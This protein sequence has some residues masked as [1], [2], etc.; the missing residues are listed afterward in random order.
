MESGSIIRAHAKGARHWD[1]K[2]P[3]FPEEQ[4]KLNVQRNRLYI[5]GGHLIDA[6]ISDILGKF[7]LGPLYSMLLRREGQKMMKATEK[8]TGNKDAFLVQAAALKAGFLAALTPAPAAMPA[9]YDELITR[10]FAQVLPLLTIEAG[11]TS[12]PS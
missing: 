5:E 7:G 9:A 4:R 6:I 3:E 1:E 11:S 2:F 12:V 8:R 10:V